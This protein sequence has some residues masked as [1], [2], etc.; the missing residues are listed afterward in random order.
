MHETLFPTVFAAN[1]VCGGALQAAAVMCVI[2]APDQFSFLAPALP[3]QPPPAGVSDLLNRSYVAL[4]D[5]ISTEELSAHLRR[6]VGLNI[7]DGSSGALLVNE[8][9]LNQYASGRIALRRAITSASVD[10]HAAFHIL[11]GHSGAPQLPPPLRGSISHK[12]RLA[13]GMALASRSASAEE[14][15]HVGCDIEHVRVAFAAD[16]GRLARLR[17]RLLTAGEQAR[18][19]RLLAMEAPA[20]LARK[21]AAT[22]V[23]AEL[24]LPMLPAEEE[25]ALLFSLKE[26]VFK[27]LHPILR[28]QIDWTEVDITLYAGGRAEVEF[29]LRSHPQLQV[30][31]GQSD[32]ETLAQSETAAPGA[33]AG[34]ALQCVAQYM[35]YQEDEGRGGDAY[36]LTFVH[37]KATRGDGLQ[38]REEVG[39]R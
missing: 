28:R 3:N 1:G 14:Q 6:E 24:R 18:L 36:W 37:I 12:G 19:G 5:G 4:T 13:L 31:D 27:A 10:Q 16:T 26:S 9:R 29:R 25:L 21:H 8:A 20:K 30:R 33:G 17:R 32:D 39:G 35:R 2:P 23:N 22:R 34:P 7:A 15:E 11:P 38:S